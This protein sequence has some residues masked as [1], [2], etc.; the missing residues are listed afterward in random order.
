M[1]D[2]EP[3][4]DSHYH[5]ESHVDWINYVWQANNHDYIRTLDYKHNQFQLRCMQDIKLGIRLVRGWNLVNASRHVKIQ[6][7]YTRRQTDHHR[8][9]HWL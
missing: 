4:S 6:V 8:A 2:Q 5:S 7:Q 9:T 3:T 1:D